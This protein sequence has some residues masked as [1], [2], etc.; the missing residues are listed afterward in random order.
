MTVVN[1]R[2]KTVVYIDK[3]LLQA[4][5]DDIYNIE[6]LPLN[7]YKA[8]PRVYFGLARFIL[9]NS[10]NHTDIFKGLTG[11]VAVNHVLCK[12]CNTMEKARE[13]VKKSSSSKISV[14]CPLLKDLWEALRLKG[15]KR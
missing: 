4:L 11:G 12:L 10:N 13:Y 1:K 6:F 5:H 9:H 14:R 7:Y 8:F 2:K 3:I 15:I